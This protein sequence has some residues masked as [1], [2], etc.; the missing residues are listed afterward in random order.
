ME[1]FTCGSCGEIVHEYEIICLQTF[2]GD[3]VDPPEWENFCP[4][5]KAN[6]EDGID[7]QVCPRCEGEEADPEDER[8]PCGRCEGVGYIEL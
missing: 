3:L 5:C 2:R 6:M 1:V 4:W 7:M 8:R